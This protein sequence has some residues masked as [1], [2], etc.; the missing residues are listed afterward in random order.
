MMVDGLGDLE[1]NAFLTLCLAVGLVLTIMMKAN[2]KRQQ[3]VAEERL[4][5]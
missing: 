5:F 1:A 2:L 3:A 4:K